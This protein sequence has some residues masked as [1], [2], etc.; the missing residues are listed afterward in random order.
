MRSLTSVAEVAADVVDGN[1]KSQFPNPKEIPMI[2]SQ[3]PERSLF[4]IW[5]FR[6]C[7]ELGIWDLEFPR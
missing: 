2:K 7:L 5:D 4:E 6:V 1:S 3:S